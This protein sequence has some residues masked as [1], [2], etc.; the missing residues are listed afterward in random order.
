MMSCYLPGKTSRDSGVVIFFSPPLIYEVVFFFFGISLLFVEGEVFAVWE[1]WGLELF[2]G[3]GEGLSVH[4][5]RI[6]F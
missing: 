5:Q 4:I 6:L 1:V 2:E 3:S